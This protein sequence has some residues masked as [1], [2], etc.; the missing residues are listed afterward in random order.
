MVEFPLSFP[1]LT[2]SSTNL[3]EIITG[4]NLVV[5]RDS[6]LRLAVSR[7]VALETSREWRITK[8]KAS[9]KINVVVALAMAAL[10]AVQQGQA[11]AKFEYIPVPLTPRWYI[12]GQALAKAE[13]HPTSRGR[14]FGG[15]TW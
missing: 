10:G 2:E 14:L 7:T 5:Y 8:E 4:R 1:N 11:P 9:H 3:Y 15:G 6:D 13:D 12:D